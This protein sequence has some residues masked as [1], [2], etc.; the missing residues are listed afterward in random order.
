MPAS[1]LGD[2][3]VDPSIHDIPIPE[4]SEENL[5]PILP[6]AKLDNGFLSVGRKRPSA[7]PLHKSKD[8]ITISVY[9]F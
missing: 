1:A 6:V 9:S 8:D 2:E 5:V 7:I 3:Q 4:V